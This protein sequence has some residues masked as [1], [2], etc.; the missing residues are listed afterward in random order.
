MTAH[1][2]EQCYVITFDQVTGPIWY[3]Q[4]NTHDKAIG[5]I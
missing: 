5:V 2:G 1:C 4:I 3:S